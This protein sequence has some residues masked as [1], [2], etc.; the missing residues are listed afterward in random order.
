MESDI[1]YY[2]RRAN[3]EFAAADRAVT[4][5][6]R[7]RRLQLANL[8]LE[9]LNDLQ[10]GGALAANDLVAVASIASSRDGSAFD[11]ADRPAAQRA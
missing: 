2:R 5:A 11:W 9:R 6:A 7:D 1:R 10:S 4:I 3:E 8:F